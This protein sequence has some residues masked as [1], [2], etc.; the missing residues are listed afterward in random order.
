M[1]RDTVR[2][3]FRELGEVLAGL[4]TIKWQSIAPPVAVDDRR[5]PLR[6]IGPIVIGSTSGHRRV[7]VKTR[8][9]NAAAL[10]LVA[11]VREVGAVD[12]RSTSIVRISH[13][14]DAGLGSYG[15]ASVR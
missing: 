5:D 14:T 15:T 6:T 2:A 10:E 4:S 11:E 7:E 13:A 3:R 8:H 12:R 1:E 9:S